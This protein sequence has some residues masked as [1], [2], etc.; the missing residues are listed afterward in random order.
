MALVICSECGAKVSD[1]ASVCPQCGA[2]ISATVSDEFG[3]LHVEWEGKWMAMD[4]TVDLLINGQSVGKYSFKDGFSVDVPIPSKETEVTVKCGFR[5]AKHTFTFEPHQDYTCNLAYS[6]LTGGLGFEV[7]DEEGNVTSDHLSFLLG[8][9]CTLFPI[10]GF[11]YAFWVKKDKP[12]VFQTAII[13]AVCGFFLG[14]IFLLILGFPFFM[15]FLGSLSAGGLLA[16]ICVIQTLF[17]IE[18]I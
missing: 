3:T 7:T 13:T 4:T 16:V 8:L 11:L 6:R 17:A 14:F 12:A 2:P 1:K 10:F 15:A 18:I 9:L 5:T